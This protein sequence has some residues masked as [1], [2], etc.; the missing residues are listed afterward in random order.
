LMSYLFIIFRLSY[1]IPSGVVNGIKIVHP[2]FRGY[3]QQVC[4]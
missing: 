3:A 4:S 1:T 2:M